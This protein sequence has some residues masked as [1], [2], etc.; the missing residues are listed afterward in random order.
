MSE[1]FGQ[2]T[3]D[4]VIKKRD[5]DTIAYIDTLIGVKNKKIVSEYD[6][7]YIINGYGVSA[8]A[9]CENSLNNVKK[10]F[11]ALEG[12]STNLFT[13]QTNVN[14]MYS[15]MQSVTSFINNYEKETKVQ[16]DKL[17][18][19]NNKL[20]QNV[21]SIKRDLEVAQQKIKAERWKSIGTNIL[22]GA[23]GVAIGGLLFSSLLLLK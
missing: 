5:N 6:T 20:N 3:T 4:F 8:F 7:L 18:T 9:R 17:K 22:W 19:D 23:G 10:S 15:N 14:T 16:L 12:L 21:E 2:A 13:I 11:G 1:L